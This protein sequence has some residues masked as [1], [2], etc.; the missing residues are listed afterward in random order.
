MSVA[1]FVDAESSLYIDELTVD[2][3]VIIS[4]R[5]DIDMAG[6]PL[7]W[8]RICDAIPEVKEQLVIDLSQ[9]TFI[10]SSA[11]AV[12]VK[13]LKRLRHA[14]ADLV[15]RAPS[16]GAQKILEIT[17]LDRVITIESSPSA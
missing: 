3:H 6:A 15:L 7:L 10:D 12:F 13:A 2:G 16:S 5:G 14:D 4:P 9:T 11:L 17:G 1:S 8:A